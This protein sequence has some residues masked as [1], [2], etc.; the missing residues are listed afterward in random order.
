MSWIL[1]KDNLG[2]I[3]GLLGRVCSWLSVKRGPEI[4]V[5][6]AA[7]EII[8]KFYYSWLVLLVCNGNMG[9]VRF[10]AVQG[11]IIDQQLRV[12]SD[13]VPTSNSFGHE[14]TWSVL[15]MTINHGKS[16]CAFPRAAL[17]YP[18]LVD[19][20]HVPFS[21]PPHIALSLNAKNSLE[22][23]PILAQNT[24]ADAHTAITNPIQQ[25]GTR[26]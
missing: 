5:Y 8:R 11:S 17:D 15:H 10:G 6:M 7:L 25:T 2:M 24:E 20:H 3:S 16:P 21:I 23:L 18:F 4:L 13:P 19:G 1:S 9:V 12:N 14:N 26:S 22:L